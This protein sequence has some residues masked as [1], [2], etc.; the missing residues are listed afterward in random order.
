MQRIPVESNRLEIKTM[1]L[2]NEQNKGRRNQGEGR[3]LKVAYTNIDGLISGLNELN[4]YLLEAKPDIMGIVETKLRGEIPSTVIGQ[5]LYNYW[6]KNRDKKQGGGIMFLA[7]KDLKVTKIAEG[8]G[9]AELIMIK[10]EGKN[11]KSR[12]FVV[13]Y[14]PPKTSAWKEIEH[15]KMLDDT[16]KS[17]NEILMGKGNLVVMGDFNCKEICWDSM[18]VQGGDD[19]WGNVLLDMTMEYTMTQWVHENTRYRNNEEPSKLDL[20]FTTEPEIV[21]KVQYETPI[22]KSDHVLIETILKEEI[23]IERNEKHRKG[24]L[25]YNKTDFTKLK[26]FFRNANWEI[27]YREETAVEEK[28]NILME[29]YNEGVNRHVPRQKRE[30]EYIKC[31]FNKRC[32][33]AK[34]RRDKAW[35]KWRKDKKQSKW[36]I[37]VNYRN[38]YVN[39]R[40]EEKRNHEKDII[41]KCKEQPKLFYRYVNGKLKNKQELVKLC[42]GNIE[43]TEDLEMAE[44]MNNHFKSVFTREKI[45]N[46]DIDKN[47]KSPLMNE[48]TASLKEISEH[49]SRLD[50]RKS[51]GPDGIANW[52]LKECKEELTD[53]IHILINSSLKEGKIPEDWKNANIVPIHKGGNK[54]EPTNY[55]PVSL[56]STIAKICEKIIKNRWVKHLEDNDILNPRQFGFRQGRSCSTNLICFYS[57][58]IDIV[59]ERN[60]WADC[61]FLDLQKAFDKVPHRKL[62]KKLE[63]IGGI[64]GNLLKWIE[65]FLTGRKMRVV[66][67][68][69]YSDWKEVISGVPQGSVL[70]PIM[71]AIYM[72]DMDEDVNCYMSFFADDAKLLRKIETDEDCEA[73]QEDLNRVWNWSQKWECEE[74]HHPAETVVHLQ[75]HHV[76]QAQP[77]TLP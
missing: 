64:Q 74:E 40:R 43:Y 33:E 4:D 51:H 28:W 39:V 60:G 68:E 62:L 5:G 75:Q 14:V 26:T 48:F 35:K 1:A 12:K 54:E 47:K 66:L 56:T 49:L 2:Q 37:Y 50:V 42:Q 9:N 70:A 27:F 63:H 69:K 44:V 34:D 10:V 22:G 45:P 20:I 59:Q 73:L 7:K 52:I 13:T 16:R 46:C 21:H 6:I 18:T 11:M 55:R 71:F 25:R 67:R 17:L 65:D 77:K 72:N 30:R 23:D 31:W 76:P 15:K 36:Q 19:S 53:K 3:K 58:L 8:K 57:R 29:N 41:D 38:E 24:R 61:A 32:S